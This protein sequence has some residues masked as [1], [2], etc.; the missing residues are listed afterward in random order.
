MFF[1][2]IDLVKGYNYKKILRDDLSIYY[3]KIDNQL[4][5]NDSSIKLNFYFVISNI[6][7]NYRTF[8]YDKAGFI[9][10]SYDE[11]TLNIKYFDET[12]DYKQYWDIP[13]LYFPDDV[14]NLNLL[15]VDIFFG[16]IKKILHNISKT[17]KDDVYKY[18]NCINAFEVYEYDF[19]VDKNT[20]D[21]I[22]SYIT[23]PEFCNFTSIKHK[24]FMDRYFNWLN[25][26]IYKPCLTGKDLSENDKRE[27]NMVYE[28]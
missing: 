24:S 10:L 16:K 19:L 25:N 7:D 26:I 4:I 22:L 1:N 5:Y 17:L 23:Y 15:D 27:F 21:P 9:N 8:V 28:S 3:F 6:N 12:L 2:N 20:H 13:V 14:S 11:E 18:R